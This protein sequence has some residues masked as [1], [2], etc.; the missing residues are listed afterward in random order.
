MRVKYD[1]EESSA[2]K[3][4]F[5]CHVRVGTIL[6][7]LWHLMVHLIVLGF[8]VSTSLHPE[9]LRDSIQPGSSM[10]SDGIIVYENEDGGKD[11]QE[12]VIQYDVPSTNTTM[13][14]RK[15]NMCLFF[16][17]VLCKF[18]VALMMVYGA[19]RSRPSCLMPFFCLQVF[20]F[21]ITCLSVVSYMTYAPD[22]KV[23]VV[24]QGMADSP[25]MDQLL[26]MDERWLMLWF[27][28]VFVLILSFQAYLINMVWACYKYIQL[29]LSKRSVVRE[30]TT[31]PD[32]E[33]LL[34]PK[35]EE[36]IRMDQ[37]ITPP[38]PYTA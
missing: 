37:N 4:C 38:P 32:G 13:K 17:L 36:A 9:L 30:Y 14:M 5:C 35:Y 3:C 23:W 15:E 22:I 20:E 10:D 29:R 28:I 33:L 26:Q 27:V 6:L 2:F 19:V 11:G 25:G 34:P 16:A 31:D 18:M 24:Q 21:C 8:L 12:V 7:G 1:S